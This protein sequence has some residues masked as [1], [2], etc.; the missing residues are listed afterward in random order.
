MQSGLAIIATGFSQ[1][2]RRTGAYGARPSSVSQLLPVTD[3]EETEYH[4]L[5]GIRASLIGFC[6]SI[7][8][9]GGIE[10]EIKLTAQE[11]SQTVLQKPEDVFKVF[12]RC[13]AVAQN[14]PW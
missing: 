14:V 6:Q 11:I 12:L 7:N 3:C 5:G 13:L 4:G 8:L 10:V 2:G 1:N 9:L